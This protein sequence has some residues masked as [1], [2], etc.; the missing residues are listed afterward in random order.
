ML[1]FLLKALGGT[2]YGLWILI[3]SLTGY[4]GLLDLGVRGALCRQLAFH[5][6]RRSVTDV[7][8]T[9]STGIALLIC[10]CGLALAGGFALQFVFFRV[11]DV[12]SSQELSVRV[13]LAIASVTLAIS[14]PL[15]AFDAAL[16]G[17][18]RFDRT[19]QIDVLVSILRAALVF[20]LIGF[21]CG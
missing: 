18:Q 12:P 16:W 8:A 9:L 5:S 15:T 17:A 4:F 21:C 3:G 11:F 14:F 20:F 2:T 19:N 6:A 10:A 13:A 1:P 7:N